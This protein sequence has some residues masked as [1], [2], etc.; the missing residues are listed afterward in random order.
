MR[1]MA[2]LIN[3]CSPYW[4]R[5]LLRDHLRDL[6]IGEIWMTAREVNNGLLNFRSH[7]AW[8]AEPME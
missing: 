3:S 8:S 4:N 5:I 7:F 2:E 6:K 1:D